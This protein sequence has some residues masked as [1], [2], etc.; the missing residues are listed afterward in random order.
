L[1]SI[2]ESATF[3]HLSRKNLD[4]ICD[5]DKGQTY[6]AINERSIS[7]SDKED[8][9]VYG[10][11]SRSIM[12]KV[13]SGSKMRKSTKVNV[14]NSSEI[15]KRLPRASLIGSVHFEQSVSSSSEDGSPIKKSNNS[16]A[17]NNKREQK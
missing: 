8:K 6:F 4:D 13:E 15:K 7:S 16:L 17:S 3:N 10:S 11:S 14:R 1:S 9:E 2:K 5:K 12:E